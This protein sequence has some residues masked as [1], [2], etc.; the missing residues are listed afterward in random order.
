VRSA[1]QRAH[2]KGGDRAS[3]CPAGSLVDDWSV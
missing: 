1:E 2:A 3:Q